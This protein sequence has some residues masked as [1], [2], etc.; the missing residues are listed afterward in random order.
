MFFIPGTEDY[1][2]RRRPAEVLEYYI[3]RENDGDDDAKVKFNETY[4]DP[5]TTSTGEENK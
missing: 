3:S 5:P 4:A 2:F 1:F